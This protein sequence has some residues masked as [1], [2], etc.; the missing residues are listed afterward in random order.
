MTAYKALSTMIR[1]QFILIMRILLLP[2]PGSLSFLVAEEN[3]GSMPCL[4]DLFG[5]L[6]A[7]TVGR[8]G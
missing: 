1:E 2:R 8:F 3:G 4:P 6:L 7:R 5:Y